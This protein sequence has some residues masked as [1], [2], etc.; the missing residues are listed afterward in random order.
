LADALRVAGGFTASADRRRV[1]IERIIPPAERTA[2]MGTDRRLI[3]VASDLFRTGDGPPEPLHAGDVVRVLEIA[4]RV[5]GR[6]TLWGNVWTPGSVAFAAGMQLSDA[7]RRAG[8][9]RPDSYLGEVLVVRLRPDSTQEIMRTSLRDTTGATAG[10]FPLSDGDDITVFSL[11]QFRPNRY[12]TIAG[13][14]RKPGQVRYRIGMT[15]RDLVLLSGGLDE[16]AL[17]TEAEIAHLPENRAAGAT[18]VTVRVPLDSSYL[19]GGGT[20][21]N[22]LGPPGIPAPAARAADVLLQPYDAVLILRQPDWDLQRNVEVRGEVR[23]PGRYTLKSKGERLSDL[24]ARAG[25][26]TPDAYP[27]GV[28]FIRKR[29][30][31]GRVGIDLPRVLRNPSH[32]D[33][34]ALVDGDSIYIPKF[35]PVIAVRGAVNS[36]LGVAYVRGAKIDFYVRSAGGGNNKADIKRAY[37]VQSNGKVESR[38][39]HMLF[40]TSIPKPEPGSTVVVP[41]KDPNEKRDWLAIASAGASILGSLVAIAAIVR[42]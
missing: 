24:L 42:R 4:K 23:Y 7:L 34:L 13:A 17:L 21:P 1:Q 5:T 32:I 26:L 12:V 36:P 40:W 8:G 22:Y 33:N 9:L 41:E 29:D 35:T 30:T 3:E 16:S 19:F 28:A 39:R 14:V 27:N 37:V 11:A 20:S 31:T 25:G 2:G 6:I 18:A 10:D 38:N 15:L